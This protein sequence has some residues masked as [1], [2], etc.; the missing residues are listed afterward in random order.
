MA[1]ERRLDRIERHLHLDEKP[2]VVA[3]DDPHP[4]VKS[5]PLRGAPICEI[6]EG[7]NHRRDVA[8]STQLSQ[9]NTPSP[10]TAVRSPE[11]HVSD[12]ARESDLE[13]TRSSRPAPSRIAPVAPLNPIAPIRPIEPIASSQLEPVLAYESRPEPIQAAGSQ[14]PLEQLIGLKLAGWVGA[15]VLVIGAGLGIKYLYDIHFF[16]GVSPAVWLSLLSLIGFALIAAGEYVYRKINTISATGLFGAGVATLFL[17]SYAGHAYYGFY[18]QTTAFTLMA[19]SAFV[20]AAVAMRGR[21]VSIG[22]LSLVGGFLAP[23]VLHGYSALLAPFLSYLLAL[24]TVALVLA[25]WGASAR[26][27]TLRG[28]SLAG[29][30]IWFAS[31]LA[32]HPTDTALC[33]TFAILLAGLYQ[34][35]L[36]L[37]T[38]RASHDSPADATAGVTFSVLVTA[39]LTGALLCIFHDALP[40]TRGMWVCGIAAITLMLGTA[41]P[42]WSGDEPRARALGYAYRAQGAVLLLIAVPITFGGATISLAWAGM[43]LALT[44]IGSKLNDRAARITGA[45]AWGLAIVNLARWA[46]DPHYLEQS[47]RAWLMIMGQRV[48]AWMLIGWGISAIGQ[49]MAWLIARHDTE[50]SDRAGAILMSSLATTLF[51]IVT[52]AGLPPLGATG[53]LLFYV[54]LLAGADLIAPALAPLA[55]SASVLALIA[56]KWVVVDTLLARMAP[57]WSPSGS[58]PLLNRQMLLGIAI[59]GSMIGIYRLRHGSIQALLG[60]LSDRANP[61]ILVLGLVTIL[62]TFGLT[63]EIERAVSAL[64][65]SVWPRPQMLQMAFTILWIFAAVLYLFLHARIDPASRR[66]HDWRLS[67]WILIGA[68]AAKFILV[69]SLYASFTGQRAAAIMPLLN[70]QTFT[71]AIVVAGLIAAHLILRSGSQTDTS[72]TG[73]RVALAALFVLLWAGTLEIDR[74]VAGGM[75]PGLLIW[76]RGQL[77]Q[78]AWTAWWTAGTIGFITVACLRDRMILRRMP[79]MRA[80]AMAPVLITI[81][82][83]LFDTL[84][85]RIFSGAA[86]AMVLINLQ[87][88]CA[89][90]VFV[91]LLLVRH[92]A[93]TALAESHLED[94]RHVSGSSLAFLTRAS[95]ALAVALLLIAGSI[96]IDRAFQRSTMLLT[97]LGDPRLAEQV[98]L[99][100]FWSGFAIACIV[101]GFGWRIAGLRYFGLTLF[102]LTLLKVAVIDLRDARTGYRILSFMAL[103]ALLLVTSVVYGK[104]T[105]RLLRQET[106][107]PAHGE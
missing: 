49:A 43:A 39:L 33:T 99:S 2:A 52:I 41:L 90:A 82:Y 105:P 107:I 59:A 69:D 36:I 10:I 45:I 50:E 97:S 11:P 63:M 74:L 21:L 68:L 85:R 96:E 92:F 89:A 4:Q 18:E 95:C 12:H 104:L 94:S 35:E 62:I 19:I 106:G 58:M 38:R 81:K 71:A 87:T 103:G 101:G 23:L 102:A 51:A 31:L 88:F 91:S 67:A 86:P 47:R 53:V 46:Q 55:Q 54:W 8:R 60:R 6:V 78:L 27:W 44:A 30:T 84:A 22:V 66:R 93:S 32:T 7:L 48:V 13:K 56:G 100:I 61:A 25:W 5:P 34:L 75:L 70:L 98:A 40:A 76:P 79:A 28:V 14:S 64:Q 83:I 77:R 16:A 26:W 20:G 73:I 80:L 9:T 65:T 17:V 24:Q 57:G 42:R 1:I 15:I 29:N 37:S 3:V 72:D